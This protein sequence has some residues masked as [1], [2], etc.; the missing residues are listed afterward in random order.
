V[1][2]YITPKTFWTTQ[3]KRNMRDLILS[4]RIDYIFDTA[5][6]FE[7]VMVDTCITQTANLPMP[8]GHKVHFFDGTE[9]LLAPL[10]YAPIKAECVY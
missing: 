2:S 3:T 10:Q 9:D 5:N 8:E 1:L 7:A 6:P 4:K